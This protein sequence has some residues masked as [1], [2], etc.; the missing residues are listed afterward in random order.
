VFH[1][2]VSV[3]H[4]VKAKHRCFESTDGQTA[5]KP[6]LPQGFLSLTVASSMVTVLPT[7]GGNDRVR[8]TARS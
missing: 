1:L 5:S 4:S 8:C 3:Q 7:D 2:E 6:L